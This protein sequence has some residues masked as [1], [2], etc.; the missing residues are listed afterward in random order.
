MAILQTIDAS[1]IRD[2]IDTVE[3]LQRPLN[4]IDI[5]IYEFSENITDAI[6]MED[7][8]DLAVDLLDFLHSQEWNEIKDSLEI[9]IKIQEGL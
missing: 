6:N 5:C 1:D 3:S 7:L 2:F 4:H 9:L 8:L